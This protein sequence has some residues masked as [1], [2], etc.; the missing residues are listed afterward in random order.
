VPEARLADFG[1]GL[2][3]VTD[4]WFVVNVR[5]AE[6]WTVRGEDSASDCAFESEERAGFPK[7][8]IS[9]VALVAARAFVV[10]GPTALGLG[11]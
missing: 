9:G 10:L 2:A 5:D 1:S 4:G 3:P 11:C 7:I 6:W 8:G